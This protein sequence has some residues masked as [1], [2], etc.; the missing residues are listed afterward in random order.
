M[1]HHTQLM[2]FPSKSPDTL[3]H[4]ALKGAAIPESGLLLG[5]Q[6]VSVFFVM[7]GA[8]HGIALF[9]APGDTTIR[10]PTVDP[11]V[12]GSYCSSKY[13]SLKAQITLFFGVGTTL[14]HCRRLRSWFDALPV[15]HLLETSRIT[16][17]SGL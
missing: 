3:C 12:Q 15:D 10:V 1:K 13:L 17:Q 7:L 14:C 11:D 9:L 16:W 4:R 2:N 8:H 5:H 6:L